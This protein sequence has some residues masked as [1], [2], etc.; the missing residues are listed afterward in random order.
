MPITNPT[1]GRGT[2][3]DLTVG[4]IVDMDEAIYLLS[5]EDSPLL[6]GFNSEGLAVLPTEGAQQIKFEWLDEEFLTPRTALASAAVTADTSIT[7][8]AGDR[9]KFSTGD[10]LRVGTELV[11]VTGYGTT[12]DTLLVSRAFGG[13]TAA[14]AASAAAV[15]GLGTAL[16]EG[17]D[18]ENA[19]VSDRS[20]NY[21]YLQIFGPTALN[22]SRTEQMIRRYG[23]SDE[24]AHQLMNRTKENAIMREQAYLYGWRTNDS[25]TKIRTTG[26]LAYHLKTNVDTTSTTLTVA[27]IQVNQQKVYNKGGSPGMGVVNPVALADLNALNDTSIVR[28]VMTETA[29]GRKRVTEIWTEF[30]TVTLVRNR[31]CM[32]NDFFLYER[33]QTARKVLRPMQFEMLAK[34]GDSSKGQLVG[35]EGFK[36]K[37]EQHACRM[38]ALAYTA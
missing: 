33:D 13:T 26:G 18:P 24:W 19:R 11:R 30:G 28:T 2:S 31:W 3:Y 4:T 20:G 7:V 6:T 36:L 38:S 14:S 27:T 29:R 35:E 9:I 17:S 15:L 5:P 10:V 21:N 8:A 16:P 23:V 25:T 34:T 32:P 37:G 1:L 22:M 12:A